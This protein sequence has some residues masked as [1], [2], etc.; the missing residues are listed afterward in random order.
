MLTSSGQKETAVE[1]PA[2]PEPTSDATPVTEEA[3]PV[4]TSLL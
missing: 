4:W 3:K 2:N 1:S